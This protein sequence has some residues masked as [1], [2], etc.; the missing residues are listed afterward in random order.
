MDGGRRED[1]EVGRDTGSSWRQ[2]LY[3]V[4]P[5]LLAVLRPRP[6]SARTHV[7]GLALRADLAAESNGGALALDGLSVSVDVGDGDLNRSVVLGGD[8]T[9]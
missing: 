8:E 7:V 3:Q 5:F 9:V 2:S 1:A 4:C 6:R